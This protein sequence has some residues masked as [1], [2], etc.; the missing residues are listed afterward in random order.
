M[1]HVISTDITDPTSNKPAP[2][3][4]VRK[5]TTMGDDFHSQLQRQH[6]IAQQT[7]QTTI[8][9]TLSNNPNLQ[10]YQQQLQINSSPTQQQHGSNQPCITTTSVVGNDGVV[11]CTMRDFEKAQVT[12]GNDDFK[13]DEEVQNQRFGHQH[14]LSAPGKLVTKNEPIND[15]DNGL[16]IPKKECDCK[17][18]LL[19]PRVVQ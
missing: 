2:T 13:H 18:E 17:D 4:D 14:Q 3:I 7:Q 19:E 6:K 12:L 10:T 8:G 15:E 16:I 11:T 9:R 5:A 1:S